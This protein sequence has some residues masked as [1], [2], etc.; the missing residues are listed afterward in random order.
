MTSNAGS[1]SVAIR[2]C[3]SAFANGDAPPCSR[4]TDPPRMA[5]IWQRFLV[6]FEKA[7]QRGP[8]CTSAIAIKYLQSLSYRLHIA[9]LGA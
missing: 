5:G 7:V 2:R 8:A 3:A 4:Q 9:M 6:V 1:T